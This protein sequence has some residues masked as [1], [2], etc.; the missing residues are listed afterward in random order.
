MERKRGRHER[1]PD[2]WHLA[3]TPDPARP[4]PGVRTVESHKWQA[5]PRERRLEASEGREHPLGDLH[6]EKGAESLKPGSL[7]V[8]KPGRKTPSGFP[9]SRLPDFLYSLVMR[10]RYWFITLLSLSLAVFALS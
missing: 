7:E 8:R 10:P 5:D 9:T 4:V 2:G 6:V 3:R 1:P